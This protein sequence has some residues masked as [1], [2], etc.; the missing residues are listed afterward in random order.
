MVQE[1]QKNRLLEMVNQTQKNTREAVKNAWVHIEKAKR[2]IGI[3]NEM[4]VFRAITGEEEVSTGIIQALK[5]IDYNNANLLNTR[6]HKHKAGIWHLLVIISE[7]MQE[8]NTNGLPSITVSEGKNELADKLLISFPSPLPGDTRLVFPTP[9]LDFNILSDNKKI[10]FRKQAEKL[11]SRHNKEKLE[12]FLSK[13]ANLR[14][15]LLYA[16]PEGYPVVKEDP[17]NFIANRE[18]RILV[19][20]YAYLLISQYKQKQLF[21]QQALD[22]YL[23]MLNREDSLNLHQEL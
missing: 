22:A 18:H 13:E 16:T 20:T 21:V 4:A 2:L 9:P 19:L 3:D 15:E 17:T 1:R 6:D 10:S 11:A 8:V 23:K 5:A 7:F 12:K 14:N